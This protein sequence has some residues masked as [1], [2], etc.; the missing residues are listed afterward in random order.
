M[1]KVKI[2]HISSNKTLTFTVDE[3]EKNYKD[4]VDKDGNPV[5]KVLQIFED[6]NFPVISYSNVVSAVNKASVSNKACGC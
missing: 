4:T 6:N 1:K 3:Y 2:L 5:F